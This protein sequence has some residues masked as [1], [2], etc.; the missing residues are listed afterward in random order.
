MKI[1]DFVYL[2]IIMHI[3]VKVANA[4]ENRKKPKKLKSHLPK[5]SKTI[6]KTKKNKKNQRSEQLWGWGGAGGRSSC[7]GQPL[8]HY[9]G[10]FCVCGRNV[11]KHAIIRERLA[12]TWAPT[13]FPT[14]PPIV[15]QIFVFL[16]FLVFSMV[17]LCFW[18]G[19]FGFFG[20]FWFPKG[21]ATLVC[22]AVLNIPEETGL[23]HHTG[24]KPAGLSCL[25]P[26]NVNTFLFVFCFLNG[27]AMASLLFHFCFVLGGF[28]DGFATFVSTVLWV[29]IVVYVLCRV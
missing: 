11:K 15:A 4:W 13:P 16:F 23:W 19:P 29:Y 6:E 25:S 9:R 7:L 10:L 14:P 12:Q 26:V 8:S 5:H 3:S 2:W 20:F 22:K 17:L 27:V 18:E 24:L 1:I 28:P 21:F